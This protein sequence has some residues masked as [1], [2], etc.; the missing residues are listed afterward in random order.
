MPSR[1]ACTASVARAAEDAGDEAA[2]S[3]AWRRYR[4]I[5]D[6]LRDPDELLL[7]GI[8]LSETAIELAAS[9]VERV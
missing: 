7:E 5:K 8:A 6:A 3:E 2:A 4:L 9:S 1:L